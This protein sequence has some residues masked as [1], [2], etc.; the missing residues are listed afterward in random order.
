MDSKRVGTLCV[1]VCSP[2]ELPAPK[3]LPQSAN[4][5][6]TSTAPPAALGRAFV[7]ASGSRYCGNTKHLYCKQLNVFNTNPA[8]QERQTKSTNLRDSKHFS[9]LCSSWLPVPCILLVQNLWVVVG[10]QLEIWGT[11]DRPRSKIPQLCETSGNIFFQ[12][13]EEKK[14]SPL[15]STL[16]L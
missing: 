16:G 6:S 1:D 8:V 11:V 12:D 15:H 7:L 4:H 3:Q 9:W 13:G 2:L 10:V 14:I 5:W